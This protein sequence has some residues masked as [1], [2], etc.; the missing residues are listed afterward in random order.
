MVTGGAQ[1]PG[2]PL[3]PQGPL[4]RSLTRRPC[5]PPLTPELLRARA[6]NPNGRPQ[7][8]VVHARRDQTKILESGNYKI[9]LTGVSTV[10]GDCQPPGQRPGGA[11]PLPTTPRHPRNSR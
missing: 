2:P 10:S 3:R 11:F 8:A 9:T 5:G 4:P 7:P 6:G 1:R